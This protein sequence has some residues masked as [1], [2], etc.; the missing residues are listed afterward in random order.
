M[1]AASENHASFEEYLRKIGVCKLPPSTCP[2]DPGIAPGV[3]ESHLE[4]SAHLILSLK[5]SMACWIVSD[6]AATGRKIAAAKR[7]GVPTMAGGGPYEVAVAQR[8]LPAY[9]QLCGEVGFDRIEAGSGFTDSAGSPEEIVRSA[10]RHGLE[11][12][13]EI[14]KK[15]GGPF[16]DRD[17]AVLI[18]EGRRWLSAGARRLIVEG[19]E[20]GAAIGVFDAD[21]R[22]ATGVADRLAEAFGLSTLVFEA[23]TKTSQ[24]ALLAHYGPH[25]Q[26][27]NVTLD[28]LLRVEIY[29]RGLHADA[30]SNPILRPV[31][32]GNPPPRS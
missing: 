12:E 9:L 25:V 31:A 11:V 32:D 10:A 5:I 30:F 1:T 13:Y 2:F 18:D 17:L 27:G 14:G 23:P 20:S 4:Q 16:D 29:R 24:F 28:D 8:Q 15:H 26:L 22:L 6:P 3:L 7:A 19:R 21:G